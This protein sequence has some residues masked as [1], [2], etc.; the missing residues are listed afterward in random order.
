MRTREIIR[1]AKRDGRAAGESAAS[2]CFD[3]NTSRE[4]YKRVLKGMEEGDP[5]V[6]DAFRVPDLSGE[7][8][9]D[10]TP[11]TLAADYDIDERRDPDGFLLDEACETWMN[12]ASEAFWS[13]LERVARLQVAEE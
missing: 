12:A 10:P 9:G 4:T 8:S 2:W 3:G 1:A 7:W 13:E 6:L 5:A 11:S